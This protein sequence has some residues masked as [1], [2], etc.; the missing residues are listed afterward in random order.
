MMIET[1]ME[2]SHTSD[3]APATVVLEGEFVAHSVAEAT[4]VEKAFAGGGEI[5][6]FTCKFANGGLKVQLVVEGVPAP[7]P[8]PPLEI[9][10]ADAIAPNPEMEAAESADLAKV[11][12][13]PEEPAETPPEKPD[14]VQ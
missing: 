5:K 1:K 14:T 2:F 12:V 9:V 7:P 10:P 6:S 3:D 4:E 11:E 8:P 13:K